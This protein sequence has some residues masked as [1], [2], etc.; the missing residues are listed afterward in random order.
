MPPRRQVVSTSI[1]SK[2]QDHSLVIT[3]MRRAQSAV[4]FGTEVLPRFRK[5]K[6]GN[7]VRR[8]VSMA[9]AVTAEGE[10]AARRRTTP[11]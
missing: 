5:A 11:R 6:I 8:S 3:A 1:V 2:R 9:G 7:V 4:G 10:E